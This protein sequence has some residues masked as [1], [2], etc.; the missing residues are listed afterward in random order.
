MEQDHL[1]S[2][3]PLG[4]FVFETECSSLSTRTLSSLNQ[5]KSHVLQ[6]YSAAFRT[7]YD[8]TNFN[9]W[10]SICCKCSR[11]RNLLLAG[12]CCY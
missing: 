9:T 10:K 4:L 11:S 12:N 6:R 3:K 1:K 5:F 8:V 7:N 2:C